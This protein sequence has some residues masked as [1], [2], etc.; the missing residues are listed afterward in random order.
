MGFLDRFKQKKTPQSTPKTN[1]REELARLE[2][3]IQETQPKKIVELVNLTKKSGTEFTQLQN[4]LKT[5]EPGSAEEEALF[6]KMRPAE[7]KA[8][9]MY[10][11]VQ[12]AKLAGKVQL[13]HEKDPD[14][15]QRY[16]L[17]LVA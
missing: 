12:R 1:K 4:R 8:A 7:A 10:A 5:L 13:Q 2:A 3:Q 9:V 11:R 6:K 17:E 16:P 14:F 15:T